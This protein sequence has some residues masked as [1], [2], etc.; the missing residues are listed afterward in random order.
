[1]PKETTFTSDAGGSTDSSDGQQSHQSGLERIVDPD[2]Y[3]LRRRLRQ[4]HE[5]KEAVKQRKDDAL[6]LERLNRE[7]TRGMRDRFIVEKV[8]D[9]IH[10]LRPL[11]RK[12]DREE[13]F[14]SE[15]VAIVDDETVTVQDIISTRGELE[16]GYLPYA[17]S[18]DAWDI[19]NDY[20]ENIAGAEFEGEVDPGQNPVDPAGR[21][22]E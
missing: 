4:L 1:M 18:M 8:V 5:A 7:F 2:E 20:F 10:E 13:D 11:L 15:E 22:H 17:A 16:N 21:F 12:I 9:Y 6:E 14:L 19:C 3:N